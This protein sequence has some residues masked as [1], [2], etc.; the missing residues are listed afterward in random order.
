MCRPSVP[1]AFGGE[2]FPSPGRQGAPSTMVGAVH[3][4]G[5]PPLAASGDPVE[6]ARVGSPAGPLGPP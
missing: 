3:P 2:P 5:V 4:P 1:H 6:G